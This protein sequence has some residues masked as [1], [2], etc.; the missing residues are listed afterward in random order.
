MEN[1]FKKG[2]ILGGILSAMTAIGFVMSKDD[3]GI[4][5][6]MQRDLRFLARNLKRSLNKLHDISKDK[7]D[8]L[9]V[10][11]VREYAINK[12]IT[13]DITNALIAAMQ[14]KWFEMEEEYLGENE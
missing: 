7:F 11:T 14:L 10:I 5:E 6:E 12:K 9:V 4:S 2:V 1:V 3:E 13:E 8:E